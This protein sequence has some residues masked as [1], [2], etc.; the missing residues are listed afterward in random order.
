MN[1]GIYLQLLK[2]RKY[3]KWE[4][5]LNLVKDFE[6]TPPEKIQERPTKTFKDTVPENLFQ[7]YDMHN[8][9]VTKYKLDKIAGS[10]SDFDKAL[11]IMQW[12]T[13]HTF[14]SGASTKWNSDNS[15]EILEYSFDNGFSNAINCREKAI[16]LSDCLLAIGIKSYPIA[17]MNLNC[18]GVH[19]TVHF[20]SKELKKWIL[21]DPS[22]NCYFE[23][24][25]EILSV[26]ELK[27]LFLENTNVNICGYSF[28]NTQECK[29]IYIEYFVKQLLTN[30][31]TWSDN[32]IDKRCYKKFDWTSKKDFN[33]ELQKNIF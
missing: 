19:F 26:W 21:F 30:L 2:S 14:Y 18:T 29:E 15:I 20:Y 23:S 25:S 5:Y 27:S 11:K 8:T 6:K 13:E 22:F 12:L 24:N 32:S 7:V 1:L 3:K 31:S 33:T 16:V 28:N 4:N 17:M 10:G 9:L